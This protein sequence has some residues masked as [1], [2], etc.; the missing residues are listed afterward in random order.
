MVSLTEDATQRL[1]L[2]PALVPTQPPGA[3]SQS[4]AVAAGCTGEP[5]VCS[6]YSWPYSWPEPQRE[7]WGFG[8]A[9][10]EHSLGFLAKASD[11]A[12]ENIKKEFLFHF[13]PFCSSAQGW[14]WGQE[15]PA[16]PNSFL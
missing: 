3:R 2:T 11:F 4:P 7:G 16:H 15:F 12:A 14:L 10:C 5:H 6:H 13:Y 9:A 1:P 8:A